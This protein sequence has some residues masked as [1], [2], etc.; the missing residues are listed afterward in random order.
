[1]RA[2]DLDSLPITNS[3]PALDSTELVGER[4]ALWASL[5]PSY[6]TF[7]RRYN[8]GLLDDAQLCFRTQI[9]HYKDGRVARDSQVD[10]VAEFFGLPASEQDLPGMP[11][12]LAELRRTHDAE[13]FLPHGVIAVGSCPESSLICLSIRQD[14]FGAIYFWDYYWRY[15]WSKP[16]FEPR[17][18][19]AERLFPDLASIRSDPRHPRRQEAQDALNYA[20]LVRLAD[21][22]QDWLQACW[23]EDTDLSAGEPVS[24]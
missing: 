19:T 8:G 12:D 2:P 10:A 3:Y 22:F 16:F 6:Q 13:A 9:P 1:M 7:L 17:L 15:P 24:A 18:Q 5:P 23:L 14:D 20:T 4:R 21:D 11:G